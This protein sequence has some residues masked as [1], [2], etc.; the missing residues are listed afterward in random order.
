MGG[1]CCTSNIE[2]FLFNLFNDKFIIQLPS[3]LKPFQKYLAKFIAKRRAPKVA[4]NYEMIGGRSPIL[5]ET[6]CQAKALEKELNKNSTDEYKCFIAMRYTY[7]F[8]KDTFKEILSSGI[9]SLDVIPLYPQ[10]SIAT[11]GSSFW[12]CKTLFKETK[13]KDQI[14]INYTSSWETNPYFI[15]LIR[16]RILDSLKLFP[17]KQNIK[18]LFSAHSLPAKYIEKGDPYERQI[19]ESCRTIIKN[20]PVDAMQYIDWQI[21]YQSKVGPVKWLGPNTEDVLHEVANKGFRNVLIVPISFVGDHIET[22]HELGI[23]YREVAHEAGITN[24]H[25]T[26]L[27]KANPLLIKAL[28]SCI[29]TDLY[30]E[31]KTKDEIKTS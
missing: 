17:K 9:E 5:F 20:M 13:L 7:P 2:N 26:R 21:C 19:Q 30:T 24:Y 28:A 4:I 11:T 27:P 23:E 10:Y 25:I 1:P 15:E 3:F 18:L 29:K 14:K 12:E 8:L 16:T 22:L 6:Q 31:S